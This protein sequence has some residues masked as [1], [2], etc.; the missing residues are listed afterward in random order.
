[1]KFEI[2]STSSIMGIVGSRSISRWDFALLFLHLA[3]YKLS[4]PI[5]QLWYKLE[6]C[7]K[8]V[9][10]SDDNNTTQYL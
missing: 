5:T 10:S 1:M 6:A 7:M 4:G 9:C 2:S 3:Q 8:H